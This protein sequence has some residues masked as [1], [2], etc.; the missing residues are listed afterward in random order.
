MLSTCP[1]KSVK[2]GGDQYRIRLCSNQ[3]SLRLARGIT[4]TTKFPFGPLGIMEVLAWK[5]DLKETHSFYVNT[6]MLEMFWIFNFWT[7]TELSQHRQLEQSPSSATTKTVRQYQFLSGGREHIVTRVTTLP[8]LV[9]C[10][11]VLRSSQWEKM[12]GS[13]SLELTRRE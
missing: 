7:K 9:L 1:R 4:R 6:S 10:A 8:V 5:M 13:S 11:A 3:I 12:V 2:P